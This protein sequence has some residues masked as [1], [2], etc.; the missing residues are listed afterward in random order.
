MSHNC[1]NGPGANALV[2]GSRTD[3][4]LHLLRERTSATL[5]ELS[6]RLG[7]SEM[8][9]RR[10]LKLLVEAGE[11]I[12]VP[13]GAR[14][15]NA[16]AFEKSFAER[17]HRMGDAKN[18]IGKAAAALVKP[19]EAVV[20]D[21]GTTTLCIARHL[22]QHRNIVALTPSLAVV[23]ELGRCEGIRLELTGGVYRSSSHDLVGNAV[24][25]ALA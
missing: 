18:R 21:S 10:D 9:I 15:A 14:L 11:V 17:L 7:V 22:R 24:A 2:N 16:P 20:L 23:D 25:E 13:G 1:N 12:R 19:G 3:D 6:A 5:A 4:I 8:T